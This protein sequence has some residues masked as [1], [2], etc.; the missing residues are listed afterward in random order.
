MYFNNSEV[1]INHNSMMVV[2]NGESIG[3]KSV[4][5]LLDAS[6]EA[7]MSCITKAFGLIYIFGN[8]G[9]ILVPG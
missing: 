4:N 9:L 5:D 1:F 2:K 7:A 8:R 3:D 6:P